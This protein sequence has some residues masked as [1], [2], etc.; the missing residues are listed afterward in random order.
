MKRK[1]THRSCHFVQ[2]Q[3]Q[4]Q[5]HGALKLEKWYNTNGKY[6]FIVPFEIR[7]IPCFSD[8]GSLYIHKKALVI[9]MCQ[10]WQK[11][12]RSLYWIPLELG[13]SAVV[14][15]NCK[16]QNSGCYCAAL[17]DTASVLQLKGRHVSTFKNHQIWPKKGQK[18]KK[19]LVQIAIFTLTDAAIWT[20]STTLKM[21]NGGCQQLNLKLK[22]K[23][24]KF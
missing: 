10:I 20:F 11:I 9:W 7:T 18:M 12:N 15:S 23:V 17:A 5:Q 3:K 19:S 2:N 22:K 8:F 4:Q 1:D 13:G 6:L 21:I 24:Y 16:F 14:A